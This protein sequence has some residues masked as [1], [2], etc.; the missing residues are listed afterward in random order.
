MKARLAKKSEA[1]VKPP[2][3][4]TAEHRQS[5][6]QVASPKQD[7]RLTGNRQDECPEVV[8]IEDSEE[9]EGA[10]AEDGV[11]R[12]WTSLGEEEPV[13]LREQDKVKSYS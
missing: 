13:S 7:A 8:E 1:T 11:E 12:T 4:I 2:E 9:F 6:E 3:A 5:Q 10:A